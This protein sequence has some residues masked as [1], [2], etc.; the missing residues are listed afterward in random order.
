MVL[1]QVLP[2][3]DHQYM[4]KVPHS[5]FYFCRFGL[6]KGGKGAGLVSLGS[7]ALW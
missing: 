4:T 7:V 3:I 5:C 6:G 2:R 1:N